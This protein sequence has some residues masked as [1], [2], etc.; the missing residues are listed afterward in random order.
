VSS[1]TN[2]QK[3]FM[4]F[5]DNKPFIDKL[6]NEQAGIVFKALFEYA[7][8]RIIP[9]NLTLECELVFELFKMNMDKAQ[10]NYNKVCKLRA[11]AG[12][13]G[14]KATQAKSS[15]VKQTKAKASNINKNK[16]III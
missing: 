16:N 15:K 2:K 12:R 5:Y 11:E 4:V 14:G 7:E 9:D 3:A 1:T 6:N 13:K 8:N 10:K